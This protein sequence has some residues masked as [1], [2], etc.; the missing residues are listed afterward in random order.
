MMKKYSLFLIL[1]LALSAFS[2]KLHASHFSS[3]DI[4]YEYIGDSTGVANQYRIY[5][6]WHLNLHHPRSLGPFAS[7]CISSSCGTDTTITLNKIN[8]TGANLAP[9]NFP[10]AWKLANIEQYA[11]TL[12][13]N[14]GLPLFAEYRYAGNI[15]HPPR[16][17][18]EFSYTASSC[19][20]DGAN[21]INTI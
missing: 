5:F 1:I 2:N 18:Y 16:A 4:R 14:N 12:S 17:D 7:I 10:G 6:H 20:R 15:I 11:D 3:G 19:C 8:A 21:N 9:G 13:A